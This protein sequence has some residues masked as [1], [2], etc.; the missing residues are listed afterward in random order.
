MP[1][2]EKLHEWWAQYGR[3][4]LGVVVF[5]LFLHDI[6]GTHGYIAMRRT[7]QEIER[8]QQEMESGKD[9]TTVNLARKTPVFIVYGTAVSEENNEMHFYDDIYGHDTKLAQ[10]LA[11]GYPY[12]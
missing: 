5:G 7:K 6:F 4:L 12:P 1:S 3:A 2:Q 10:A 9:N 11:K 8:V